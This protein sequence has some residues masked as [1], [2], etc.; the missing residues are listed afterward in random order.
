MMNYQKINNECWGVLKENLL[1]YSQYEKIMY[2][3]IKNWCEEI[4]Y[5]YEM[6]KKYLD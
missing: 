1:T 5:M 3:I 4:Y 2:K 6:N